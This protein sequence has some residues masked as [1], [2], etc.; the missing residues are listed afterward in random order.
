M[1]P[2]RV[3]RPSTHN[4]VEIVRLSTDNPAMPEALVLIV[5]A[6]AGGTLPLIVKWNE[7]QLHT[8]LALSTGIFLG[9]VFLHLLP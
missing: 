2:Y 8:A 9:A 4:Q 3:A 6:L 1:R 7:R 5:V